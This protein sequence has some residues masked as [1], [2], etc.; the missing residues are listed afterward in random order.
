MVIVALS[1]S[2]PLPWRNLFSS[3]PSSTPPPPT[4]TTT[5]STA[6]PI[7]IPKYPPPHK[8][9]PPP[10][11]PNP[12]FK[13]HR[14]SKYHK[15]VLPGEVISSDG[16]RSVVIGESGLSYILPGAPFE[17]QFSYSETPKVK[18]LAIRE[19]AFLPFAPPSMPRPWTGKAPLK[20]SK[21]KIP[22]FDSF[23]PPPPGM[24]GVK[25][26]E[27]PGPFKLGTYPKEG[28][29]REEILGEPLKKWEIGMLVRPLLSQ[30]RQVNLGRDGLTH[31]MLELIHSHWKRCRVCKVRCKGVPTVDMNNV[32][33]HIEEKTGGK[34]IHR[35][36]G[37]VY[38]FRGRN[39]N[40]STRPQYPVML[41]KPAAPVYPKLIQDAPEGL[42]KAE[43]DELRLKGKNLLPI[44]K[45]A[46]NGVYISLVKDCRDAFE[47][48]PLVKIDCDGLD[49]SDYKKLGAKLKELV[50]CVLLSFD[51]EKILMWRGKDW[52]PRYP[53]PPP[54]FSP[55]EAGITED[56][57]NTGEID[58]DNQSKHD[59]YIMKTSSKMLSLWNRAIES[60]KALLLEE[61]NLGP[62]AL[63]QKVEEF[64]GISQAIEHSY[65]AFISSGEDG[66][67]HSIAN[68]GDGTENSYSSDEPDA[69]DDDDDDY[70]EYSDDDYYDDDLF[71]TVDS[72]VQPGSLAV[73]YIVNRLKP[74]EE[75]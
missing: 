37:I 48:S 58:D 56:L 47:G 21:K 2:S 8:T 20:S 14:H 36:G 25:H 69:E 49:P 59:G 40:Y 7:P 3:L 74:R 64:E 55:V 35:H 22:L 23:N 5:S 12:G 17:F 29:T 63:L 30:N 41:W 54:L 38:L 27:M 24:K 13:Y 39:Y 32:C 61:F 43:A 44:C 45:L 9:P 31:N 67:K 50:P 6:T 26:V 28:K 57:D 46:K 33:H 4:T 66:V 52:K 10:T 72:S 62:D 73:D 65:P 70:D 68:F 1:S 53:K 15:P 34:I 60:E 16:D 19:P 51:D 18:P 42:T 11:S 71:D 75:R